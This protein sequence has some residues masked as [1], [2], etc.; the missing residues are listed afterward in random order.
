MM[1][2]PPS[3]DAHSLRLSIIGVLLTVILEYV[4]VKTPMMLKVKSV[5]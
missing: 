5:G 3:N 1:L 4:W 2:K